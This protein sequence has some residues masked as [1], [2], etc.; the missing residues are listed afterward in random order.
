MQ[1]DEGSWRSNPAT[2]A[3]PEIHREGVGLSLGLNLYSDNQ[4]WINHY[5]LKHQRQSR[6]RN[7]VRSDQAQADQGFLGRNLLGH[8]CHLR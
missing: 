3:E 5:W 6:L 4:F 8:R 2:G 7:S 1:R